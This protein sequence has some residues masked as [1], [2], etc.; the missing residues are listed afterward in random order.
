MKYI[1]VIDTNDYKDFEFFEDADGKYLAVKD[2][3]AK[4]EEFMALH[5][6]EYRQESVLDKI[7]AE[8]QGLRN[9]SCSCSD[10]I[11]DDVEDIIDKYRESEE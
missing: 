7:R 9:C 3:N 11:I 4:Y 10:G 8:I 5:F 2:K 1:A 6:T